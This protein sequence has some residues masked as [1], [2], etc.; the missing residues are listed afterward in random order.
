MEHPT[1]FWGCWAHQCQQTLALQLTIYGGVA[2]W[3]LAIGRW[4][5]DVGLFMWNLLNQ[6]WSCPHGHL[7][8]S[9]DIFVATTRDSAID[10][11]WVEARDTVKQPMK[12]DRVAWDR[13]IHPE[14]QQPSRSEGSN[15]G[16]SFSPLGGAQ[17]RPCPW[18]N[19]KAVM[20]HLV[21]KRLPYHLGVIS[22]LTGGQ[23]GNRWEVM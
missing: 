7:R 5:L 2:H 23:N 22:S 12:M 17:L 18:V 19:Q 9:E 10:V 20:L 3:A 1:G 4:P 6:A 15:L 21:R 8:L 16:E 14:G 11:Q 13:M